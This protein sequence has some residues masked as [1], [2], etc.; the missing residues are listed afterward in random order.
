M[1]PQIN[2]ITFSPQISIIMPTY[3]RAHIIARAIR[4]VLGQS[5]RD[6][7]LLIVSDGSRDNTKTVVSGFPDGRIRYFEKPHGGRASACNVG[8]RF[9]RGEY[10]AYLDDDDRW[11]PNHLKE[12]YGF[13]NSHPRVGMVYSDVLIC[14]RGITWKL[15]K[16]F[17]RGTLESQCLP[18]GSATMHRYACIDTVGFFDET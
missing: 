7:E 18:V 17:D 8:L 2:H 16:D 12:L 10:V 4:S 15:K 9:A 14:A 3:N 5:F 11:Y 1:S 13:L 6:F